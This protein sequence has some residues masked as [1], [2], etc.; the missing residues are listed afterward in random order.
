[1]RVIL[2]F[3][4][5][6]LAIILLATVA[7]PSHGSGGC[8]DG[9]FVTAVDDAAQHARFNWPGTD[10]ALARIN[11]HGQPAWAQRRVLLARR[12][13]PKHRGL[14]IRHLFYVTRHTCW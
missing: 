13:W 10:A 2:T 11:T 4:V 6:L 3:F 7:A 8:L 12:Y 1:M 14:T 5:I 9:R